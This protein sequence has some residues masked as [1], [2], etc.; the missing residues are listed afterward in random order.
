MVPIAL[1]RHA[2]DVD[3]Q[4]DALMRTLQEFPSSLPM[5]RLVA[6]GQYGYLESSWF[7]P[8]S[9]HRS[10]GLHFLEKGVLIRKPIHPNFSRL[11]NKRLLLT[12]F[13]KEE[14]GPFEIE[15]YLDT[16]QFYLA[17]LLTPTGGAIY[18]HALLYAQAQNAQPIDICTPDLD[19][20]IG[21]I[22]KQ[23]KARRPFLENKFGIREVEVHYEGKVYVT[24]ISSE[25]KKVRILC[26]GP[27]ADADF[28][29]LVRLS[30]DFVGVRG[31][32]SFS[33]VVSANRAFFYDGAVHA[34]YFVKDLLALAE[35]RIASHRSS[36]S[37]FRGMSKAFLHTL[38]EETEEWVEE[39][40]FQEK[41][42]WVL[43]AHS[44]GKAL[45]DPEVVLGFRKLN[46][47]IAEE[48]AFN[49]FLC[50]LVHRELAHAFSDQLAVFAE[51]QVSL[52]A[53]GHTSLPT[54]LQ[55]LR[56]EMRGQ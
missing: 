11:E 8:K 50:Q 19:W 32:Q 36:L 4:T 52:F 9:G 45:R 49:P 55:S 43:I 47:I 2:L 29:L 35:N 14:P 28:R 3:V 6:I 25:G 21:H 34:R 15:T 51:E 31:D 42:P 38:P 54:L 46:Q 44:I 20:L 56:K 1:G 53:H 12:L 13:G 16:H 5:P 27:I 22:E 40:H 39:T 17:Y 26:P 24:R 7:H 33:E 48:H 37:L 23:K 41:E 30:G 18:L 10:M